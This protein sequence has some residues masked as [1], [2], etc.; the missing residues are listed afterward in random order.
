MQRLKDLSKKVKA[1]LEVDK[2]ARNSDSIL[3]L[4]LLRDMG[5]EVGID[6]D[7]MSVPMYLLHGRDLKL[8]SLD[9]V[10]RAR[11]KVQEANPELRSDDDVE[12][13]K[14]EMEEAYRRFAREVHCV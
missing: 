8:P 10:A 1:I 13:M 6:I 11:R 7:T 12:A 5:K 14:I 9:S 3:L 2:E 4:H